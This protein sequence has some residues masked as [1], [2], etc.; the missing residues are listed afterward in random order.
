MS[1]SALKG[2]WINFS[3][4]IQASRSPPGSA[5]VKL[6]NETENDG[7]IL[8]RSPF[9]QSRLIPT[10]PNS[11]SEI[12]VTKSYD[13]EKPPAL[14]KFLQGS[15]GSGVIVVEGD[16]HKFQKK[17]LTPAFS[18]RH[19]RDL[20]PLMWRKA[21]ILTEQL[22]NQSQEPTSEI[23]IGHWAGKASLDVIGVAALGR[24]FDS[25]RGKSSD[26]ADMYEDLLR[27]DLRK[28]FAFVLRVFG[29]GLLKKLPLKVNR[30]VHHTNISLRNITRQLVYDK[31][32]AMSLGVDKHFDILSILIQSN[33]FSDEELAN[34]LLTF[35]GAG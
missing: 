15:L 12:L 32:Q 2:F 3:Y 8:L 1:N 21:L 4:L 7:V 27:P 5:L 14:R 29:P 10:A 28:Y 35:L 23:E 22:S 13:F 34:Q 20:Y 33:D 18:F 6:S 31:R 9:H 11:F 17:H 16:D 19:I 26:L 24:E 30:E 25:L